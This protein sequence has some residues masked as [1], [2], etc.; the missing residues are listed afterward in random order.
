MVVE[1]GS[2]AETV[3]CVCPNGCS[4]P[5]SCAIS[6]GVNTSQIVVE[7]ESS[8]CDSGS[9]TL[10][11]MEPLNTVYYYEATVGC[12]GDTVIITGTFRTRKCIVTLWIYYFIIGVVA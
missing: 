6:Y 7:D 8:L 1:V 3:E 4:A 9:I 11:L 2:T 5:S 12:G 10:S